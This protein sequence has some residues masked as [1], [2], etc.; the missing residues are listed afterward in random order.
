MF[1]PAAISRIAI[2]LASAGLFSSISCVTPSSAQQ[3]AS[4]GKLAAV[5]AKGSVRCGVNPGLAG[6]ALPD[7]SGQW[8]G[9][10]V[11]VCRAVAAAIFADASKVEFV[12]LSAKDRF[13]ALQSGE[14]DVLARNASWTLSRN[15]QLGINFIGVNFYDGQAFMVKAASGVTSATKL[16]GASVCVIQGTST[17]KTLADYYRSRGM[18]YEPVSFAD[19]DA[20]A[21]AYLKGR[22]DAMTSDQSQLSAVRSRFP[23][24]KE[25]LIL[26]EIITK[27]PL[28]PA[29]RNGDD[30][31]ANVVRWSFYA[32]VEAEELGLNSK[33]IADQAA[34]SND[35]AVQRFTG[36]GDSFGPMLGLDKAWALNIIQQVGNYAESFERNIKP[37]GLDRGVNRLWRDGGYM[38][39]PPVR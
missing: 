15:A 28:A 30:Q 39:T 8:H 5:K 12:P 2:L 34:S 37:I 25:H 24:P 22:C 35:P 17:E 18:R 26:P 1:K 4:D 7:S 38:I 32:M 14:I 31:W 29:V 20:V 13:T 6:F 9:L 3:I 23:E 10:D 27:E 19:A 16:D 33:N 21:E 11:D 36:K